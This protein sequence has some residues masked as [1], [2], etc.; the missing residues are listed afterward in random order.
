MKTIRISTSIGLTNI[1][2]VAEA[3][4]HCALGS[5]TKRLDKTVKIIAPRLHF[6]VVN[7]QIS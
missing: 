6:L 7:H 3:A 4:C 2:A 1:P 5:S